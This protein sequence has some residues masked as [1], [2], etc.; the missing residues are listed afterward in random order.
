MNTACRKSFVGVL[1]AA[2]VM[3]TAPWGFAQAASPA[4]DSTPHESSGIVDYIDHANSRI[5]INDREF[6]LPVD[7]PVRSGSS[8]ASR[9]NLA[10][11]MRV[12]FK[13]AGGTV[14]EIRILSR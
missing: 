9:N 5:V 7:V 14:T 6:A 13:Q 3:I 12:G 4:P 1:L 8:A 2:V 11:G 10:K